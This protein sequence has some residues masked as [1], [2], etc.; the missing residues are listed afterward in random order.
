M[1]FVYPKFLQANSHLA[2]KLSYRRFSKQFLYNRSLKTYR[3][4]IAELTDFINDNS[5]LTPLFKNNHQIG[6]AIFEGY[7]FRQFNTKERMTLIQQDMQFALSHFPEEFFIKKEVTIFSITDELDIRLQLN[8][9]NILEGLWL[10]GLYMGDT[11]VYLFTFGIGLDNKLL[12]GSI[13]GTNDTKDSQLIKKTTKIM[14]SLRPQQLM[15][16]L[17]LALAEN[18]KLDGVE[19]VGNNNHARMNWR[20]QL[21]RKKLFQ[22]DYNAIWQAYN[23][24]L[25][26][27]GNWQI[28][29]MKLKTIKEVASKKRSMY[30]KR[31]AML[32][33]ITQ[34][35]ATQLN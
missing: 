22:A 10:L 18:W 35:L 3:S 4:E 16:W 13:Q 15:I 31:Y 21:R 33:E 5:K 20:K 17:A 9:L 19:A 26:E 34:A 29:P 24:I 32:D 11:R 27:N 14:H 6:K 25:L 7:L 1:S 30:R 12:I 8:P 28:P 2:K 23:G